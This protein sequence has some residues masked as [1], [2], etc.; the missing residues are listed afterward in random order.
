VTFLLSMQLGHKL[1][2]SICNCGRH[3][4]MQLGHH[5]Y[6]QPSHHKYTGFILQAAQT[7][8]LSHWFDWERLLVG[9]GVGAI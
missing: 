4:D 7:C 6:M 2:M 3:E 9:S 8:H 5:E 1:I